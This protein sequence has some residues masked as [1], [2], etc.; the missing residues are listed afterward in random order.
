LIILST[1]NGKI[2]LPT[3]MGI[4]RRGGN[5]LDA[6]EAGTRA[7]ERNA[8]DHT[9]G[10]G[11]LPNLLGE[12]RLDAAIMD[13]RTLRAGAVGSVRGYVHVITL[14]RRVMEETP[15]VFLVGDGAE[16]FAQEMGLVREDLLTSEAE[17][18][19]RQGLHRHDPDLDL[20]LL[21]ERKNLRDI[22][23]SLNQPMKGWRSTE[24]HGTVNLIA[25]DGKGN[26]A[27]AVSTSGW[28][29]SYPGRLGDSPV[30]GAGCYADNRWGAAASTG[31]GE[32]VLRTSTTRS[33]ILYIK[34]GM[35]L[36]EATCEALKDLRDL[37]DR[38]VD[39][40]AV[41]AIDRFGE[42]IGYSHRPN[43]RYAF[44]TDSMREP[45]EVAMIPVP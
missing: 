28:P 1:I 13:G 34:M 14:A 30:I 24:T 38:Y 4:L 27:A 21:P 40:I 6:V 19:W 37:Q 8:A 12:V 25:Q 29:W 41:I 16:S 22:V 11:G 5:A 17:A 43:E 31:T 26:L 32:V 39:H 2:G 9:V 45:A 15:H 42:H 35:S 20:S 10:L 33:I 36:S 7:V 3:A 23:R 18:Q 44:M